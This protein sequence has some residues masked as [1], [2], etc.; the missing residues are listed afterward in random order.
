VEG[1]TRLE[2]R[3]G[4]PAAEEV[5]HGDERASWAAAAARE[6]GESRDGD[7]CAAAAREPARGA[8]ARDVAATA[9]HGGGRAAN[10]GGV[11]EAE[12]GR[13]RAEEPSVGGVG[14]SRGARAGSGGFGRLRSRVHDQMAEMRWQTH[15]AGRPTGEGRLT[16]L[17]LC[18]REVGDLPS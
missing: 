6:G 7:G 5:A 4:A 14:R 1:G 12:A 18:I 17:F 2:E 15:G 13:L 3:R 11:R 9:K 16:L 10:G 8:G